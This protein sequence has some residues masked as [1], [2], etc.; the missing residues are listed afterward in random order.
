MACSG[1]MVCPI[2]GRCFETLVTEAEE[3]AQ[4]SAYEVGH[5]C[6]KYEHTAA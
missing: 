1:M 4:G 2:S 5:H 6:A 3:Q